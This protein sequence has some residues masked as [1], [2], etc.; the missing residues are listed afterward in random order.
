MTR[1]PPDNTTQNLSV[2][3]LL[4]HAKYYQAAGHPIAARV[5]CTTLLYQEWMGMRELSN[6]QRGMAY[7]I[8]SD[9]ERLFDQFHEEI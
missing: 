7:A 3:A 9:L 2:D 6:P 4:E 1:L 5:I 8:P